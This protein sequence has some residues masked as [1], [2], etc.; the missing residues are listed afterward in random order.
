MIK[1]VKR[2]KEVAGMAA[3]FMEG[4]TDAQKEALKNCKD[5]SEIMA[6]LEKEGIELTDEQLE[7][8]S[9]GLNSSMQRTYRSMGYH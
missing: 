1:E 3:D 6:Y 4:L 8:V 7:A 5:A 2:L 9:G